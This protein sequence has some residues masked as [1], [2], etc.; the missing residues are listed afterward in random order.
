MPTLSLVRWLR[1]CAWQVQGR[2]A[3]C[4]AE[5]P[6]QWGGAKKQCAFILH[7]GLLRVDHDLDHFADDNATSALKR[8]S[9]SHR[10]LGD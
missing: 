5:P 4:G 6:F 3:S 7:A 9:S 8:C 2:G 1:V 10:N